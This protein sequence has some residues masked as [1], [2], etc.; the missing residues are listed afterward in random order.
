M[1]AVFGAAKEAE[2]EEEET[3]IQR[4]LRR[5]SHYVC[6]RSSKKVRQLT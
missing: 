5:Y 2:T 6:T 4:A 3:S 1:V